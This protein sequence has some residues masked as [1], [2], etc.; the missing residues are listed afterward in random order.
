MGEGEEKGKEK[1]DKKMK[2]LCLGCVSSPCFCVQ[3]TTTA[4]ER[5]YVSLSGSQ[6]DILY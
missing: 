6:W 2:A 5:T 1:N 4:Q 3:E